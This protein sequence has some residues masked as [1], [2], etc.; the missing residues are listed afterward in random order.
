[1]NQMMCFGVQQAQEVGLEEEAEQTTSGGGGEK[2]RGAMR[3]S[4]DDALRLLELETPPPE[5][6]RAA[7][8]A[9]ASSARRAGR[10]GAW[11]GCSGVNERRIEMAFFR[12]RI[13]TFAVGS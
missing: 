4:N 3:E 6:R 2:R 11:T 10:A 5:L 1:M 8:D 13:V 12:L 7:R 9:E